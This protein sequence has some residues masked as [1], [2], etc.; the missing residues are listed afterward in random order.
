MTPRPASI[1]KVSRLKQRLSPT[2]FPPH[3]VLDLPLVP[4][5]PE[6]K[7]TPTT[8]NS[9]PALSKRSTSNGLLTSPESLVRIEGPGL[10][11]VERAP[12]LF[13]TP[14]PTPIWFSLLDKQQS[15]EFS[16][17]PA[18]IYVVL[19]D[20]PGKYRVEVVDSGGKI[21]EVIYNHKVAALSDVWLEWDCLDGE[22][23]PVPPGQYFI[24]IYKDGKTLKSL[25]VVRTLKFGKPPTGPFRPS[26]GPGGGGGT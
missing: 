10:K 25:S 5:N 4:R 3:R 22:G 16:D 23:M 18:N 9:S 11:G 24:I 20:G 12:N 7:T 14:T 8:T 15:V 21:L 1:P 26:R 17:P 6:A 19:A 13:F 2:P